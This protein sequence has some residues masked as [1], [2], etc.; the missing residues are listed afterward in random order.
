MTCTDITN[1]NAFARHGDQDRFG[2]FKVLTRRTDHHRHRACDRAF[3]AATHGGVH[4]FHF[5]CVQLDKHASG[6]FR[7]RGRG[8][9]D[10]HACARVFDDTASP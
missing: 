10:Q 6:G 7:M 5:N 9:D 1:V 3:R 2:A 4:E 8:V